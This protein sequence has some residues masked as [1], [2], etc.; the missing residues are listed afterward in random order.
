MEEIELAY[1]LAKKSFAGKKNIARKFKYEFL[2]WLS[3]TRD[4]K[5][6]MKKTAP[7]KGKPF[8]LIVFS[9]QMKGEKPAL[10]KTADPLRLE[11]ISLSRI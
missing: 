10:K 7:E 1:H 8:L 2:L 9:G 4:I 5:N 6:A 11:R 3:G